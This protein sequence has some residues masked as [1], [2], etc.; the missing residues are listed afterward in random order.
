MIT[1]YV[2]RHNAE[3]AKL[4]MP[5]LPGDKKLSR[6][7]A[8]EV[9]KDLKKMFPKNVRGKFFILKTE[10]QVFY[11]GKDARDTNTF[12]TYNI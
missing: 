6:E 12:I 3:L 8:Y 5:S 4:E 7:Q 9:F 11:I 2:I 10:Q 1:L